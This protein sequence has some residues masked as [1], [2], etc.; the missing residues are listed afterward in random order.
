VV[1]P[2]A[3]DIFDDWQKNLNTEKAEKRMLMN[4]N[5]NCREGSP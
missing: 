2:S 4:I 5:K 1:V 3:Y